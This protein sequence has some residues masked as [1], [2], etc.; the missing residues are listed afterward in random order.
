[1]S[2]TT[3]A[4]Q[5]VPRYDRGFMTREKSDVEGRSAKA[6]S[7]ELWINKVETKTVQS[8]GDV[9]LEMNCSGH[10]NQN[11][12]VDYTLGKDVYADDKGL[13]W[14]K[15]T[16]WSKTKDRLLKLNVRKGFKLKLYGVFEK[17][18]YTAQDGSIRVNVVCKNVQQFEVVVWPKAPQ[19]ASA[20]A[21]QTAPAPAQQ[22]A[23][24][25]APQAAPAPTPQAAPAPTP[26][27]A[28]APTPQA[29]PA[30]TPQAAPTPAPQAAPAPAPQAAP[31]PAP[32][33]APAP[34]PQAAPVTQV[35]DV[36]VPF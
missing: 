5:D 26:Q 32:Q 14:I 20:P 36:E 24:A 30:P 8:T 13:I 33:A 6:N 11:N 7:L 27:A 31:T 22:T 28:P 25:P 12:G 16:A 21:Q 9:V 29:A 2:N 23:P 17:E 15:A 1:M 34:A 35:P 19:D 3:N 18:T 10:F 4:T